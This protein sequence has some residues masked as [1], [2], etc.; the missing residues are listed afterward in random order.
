MLALPLFEMNTNPL[1][2]SLSLSL[3]L[4]H[5]HSLT[6]THTYTYSHSPLSFLDKSLLYLNI[7]TESMS[8]VISC[9]CHHDNQEAIHWLAESLEFVFSCL[10]KRR[11]E[12]RVSERDGGPAADINLVPRIAFQNFKS[13]ILNSVDF[14]EIILNVCD[15]HQCSSQCTLSA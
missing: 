1:L 9:D 5:T 2:L 8:D 14:L 7:L 15:Y 12:C 3:S 10:R 6:H 4:I 11:E 13:F